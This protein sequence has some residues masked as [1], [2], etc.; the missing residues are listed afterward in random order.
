MTAFAA[1]IADRRVRDVLD[2]LRSDGLVFIYSTGTVPSDLRVLSEPS[3]RAGV[4]LAREILA[5]HGLSLL[6]AAPNIYSVVRD[7]S[8]KPSRKTAPSATATATP[9]EQIVVQTSRYTL[10]SD[11]GTAST[12]LSQDQLKDLPQLADETLRAVQRLPGSATNGFSSVGPV[13]GGL[14]SEMAIILDGLRLYEPFHLKNFFSPVSLLDSRLIEGIEFYSGGFPAIYGDRM[15]AIFDAHSIRPG[16][17]RYFEV[18]LNLFHFSALGS[19]E[20]A[21]DR[22]RALLS[23]RRSNLGELAQFS[24]KDYGEPEYEDAFGRF[25]YTLGERTDASLQFLV[26][27]DAITAKQAAEMQQVTAGY[28]NV[29]VWGTLEHVWSD[30]ADSRVILSYTDLK[31]QRHG[32]IDEPMRTATVKDNRIFH[33]IGLRWENSFESDMLQHRFGIEARRLWGSY[34][35]A[36]DVNWSANAPF[37]GSP[38]MHL[39]RRLT[40]EP[41]GYETLGYWDVRADLAD[42]WT[43]QGGMRVDTQTYDG[44]DDG[45]QWSP[46]L[47]VLY[48]LSPTSRLRASWGRFYQSQ[49]INELQ[50]EDGIDRFHSAEFT[51][52]FIVGFDHAFEAGLDLRVEAYRKRYRRLSPRFENMFDPLVLF[53]EA[54]YDRVMIDPSSARAYGVEALLRLRQRGAWSG[55]LGYTWSQVHDRIDGRDVPR[56]W[57]QRHAINLGIVWS[58]GPWTASL[59]N[60]YHSGWPTTALAL[61]PASA[62]PRVSTVDRNRSRFGAFNSLDLRIT[63]VFPLSRGVLDVFVEATNLT[64]RGNICCIEY[65]SVIDANGTVTFRSNTDSWLPLIPNAGFLW[66]Y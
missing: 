64:S 38:E 48:A 65:D 31:N 62:T 61:D 26:S 63:R 43:F 45:E 8:Q 66:R 23:Y 12:F 46:R 41:D 49:G 50:V 54:G 30:A 3:A 21:D 59:A 60:S 25:D 19:T 14:P 33:V 2:E 17:P 52:H 11:F 47:S 7:A 37:P 29:Y 56:S 27:R 22:G 5:P 40:P 6:Q 13:R 18:G 9:L 39:Q 53:P 15:S 44:S 1:S 58:R 57:D 55:W 20:F 16:Q 35:Y 32:S 51:D 10:H 42:R 4:D 34:N 24:E 36:S 28:R